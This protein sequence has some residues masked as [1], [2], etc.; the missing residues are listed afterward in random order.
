M[1]A[2]CTVFW[3]APVAPRSAPGLVA[4]L[5]EHER[6]R[7]A[8]FRREADAARYL[9]AHALA[10]IVVAAALDTDP[11]AL[12]IDRTCRC[13]E[14]HGKPRLTSG[15]PLGFSLTHSGDLVGVALRTDGPVGL[16]VEQVRVLPDLAAM[17]A[18]IRSPDES[19]SLDFFTAW[20]CK[21]AVLKATG[22]G[23]ATPMS[24]LTLGPG[25]R[26][27][28]WDS[29]DAPDTPMWIRC[30]SPAPGYRAAVAGFG[31]TAPDVTVTDGNALLRAHRDSAAG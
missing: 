7:V 31:A 24:A 30:L 17:T 1:A 5:D 14:P 29:E 21:E 18:Y 20:V 28:R 15:E 10:R 2:S 9:A 16:D 11:A 25:P 3:A 4:L 6:D 27:L 22:T 8:R 26:L 23:L 13:G 19:E 12:R